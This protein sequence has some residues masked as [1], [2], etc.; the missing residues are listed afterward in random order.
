MT[1]KQFKAFL[2]ENHKSTSLAIDKSVN[3][4]LVELKRIIEEGQMRQD[5]AMSSHIANHMIMDAKMETF[6]SRTEPYVLSW[7]GA[8][9]TGKN[10]GYLA[11]FLIAVGGAWLIIKSSLISVLI[12]ALK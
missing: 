10:I 12:S 11:S 7:E 1:D 6:I 5:L 3:G 8:L 9:R 4:K 2:E